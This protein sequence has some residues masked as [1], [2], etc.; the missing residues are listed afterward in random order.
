LANIEDKIQQIL[1]KSKRLIVW[2]T[3]QLALKL[4][5]DTSLAKADIVAFVD[6]NPINQGKILKDTPIIS[7]GEIGI[8][9]HPILVTTLLYQNEI[10]EQIKFL[11]LSNS[12]I[13]LDK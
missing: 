12:I 11:G 9:P 2:G 3:G 8:L 10:A 6:N 1:A 13:Y 4:L 5:A 7:P